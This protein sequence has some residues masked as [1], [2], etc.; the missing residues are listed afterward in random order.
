MLELMP[1][2]RSRSA[3]VSFLLHVLEQSEEELAALRYATTVGH[4]R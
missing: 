3:W 1:Q 4:R 2:A